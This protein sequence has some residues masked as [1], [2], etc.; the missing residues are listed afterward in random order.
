MITVVRIGS[1]QTPFSTIL[2]VLRVHLTAQITRLTHRGVH[3]SVRIGGL[4]EARWCQI[5]G[6]KRIIGIDYVPERLAI[7]KQMGIETNNYQERD[8]TKTLLEMV[9]GGVDCS[10]EAAG[11]DYAKSLLHKVER[12]S[13]FRNR[14]Q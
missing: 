1:A 12:F 8:T 13:Q 2:H 10:L 11:F 6:A 5:L 9:P 14:C 4:I 7:T 3:V